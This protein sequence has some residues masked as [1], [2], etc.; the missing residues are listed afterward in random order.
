DVPPDLSVDDDWRSDAGPQAGGA[1]RLRDRPGHPLVRI[2]A[3][4]SPGVED[5]GGDALAVERPA[6]ARLERMLT[7]GSGQGH[8][9]IWVIASDHDHLEL[10]DSGDLL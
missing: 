10:G 8:G 2:V 7:G 6:G 4:G 3:N 9:P 5:L 1:C